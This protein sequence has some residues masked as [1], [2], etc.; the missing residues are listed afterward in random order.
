M[1][2]ASKIDQCCHLSD[3]KSVNTLSSE[4][5]VAIGGTK[6][7]TIED[8][9]TRTTE[10]QIKLVSAHNMIRDCHTQPK[11]SLVTSD[12]NINN[13]KEN[14]TWIKGECHIQPKHKQPSINNY[15]QKQD[16][17]KA[18]SNPG[19][20]TDIIRDNKMTEFEVV[21]NRIK[22]KTK[23]KD[24]KEIKINKKLTPIKT[25]KNRLKYKDKINS[26][27]KI[28]KPSHTDLKKKETLNVNMIV[29]SLES[30]STKLMS[31]QGKRLNFGNSTKK[32]RVMKKKELVLPDQSPI[33]A[34]FGK[35]GVKELTKDR[36]N[37]RQ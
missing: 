25:D 28:L 14:S 9:S 4:T 15:M 18:E 13:S 16:R 26:I 32:K 19:Q 12:K 23:I 20:N 7:M 31:P 37:D 22:N 17:P 34:F 6:K 10:H 33:T 1:F 8:H 30:T 11:L 36:E 29:K 3:A 21:F 24:D 27:E 35:K 5:L 2:E